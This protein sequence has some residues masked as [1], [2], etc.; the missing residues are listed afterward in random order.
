MMPKILSS[1]GIM[2][3]AQDIPLC[4]DCVVHDLGL[5]CS[6]I[7]F[8]PLND[9]VGWTADR[10]DSAKTSN[11]NFSQKEYSKNIFVRTIKIQQNNGSTKD[12]CKK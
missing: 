10:H 12:F 2:R 11:K 9:P 4:Y 8:K 6:P 3:S 7:F 5:K 1:G